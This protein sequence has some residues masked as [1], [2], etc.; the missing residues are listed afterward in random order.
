MTE[1]QKY[2]G[3]YS[4]AQ[5][6]GYGHSNHGH[7][8]M[9]LFL[10]WQPKSVLDVGC[11]YNEFCGRLK[12][13]ISGIKAIG[14]DFACPGADVRAT[15]TALPFFDKSFEVVTSF[16]CLEHLLPEEVE[17]ALREMARVASK[18]VFSIC[19]RPSVITWEGH[20][21]HPTVQPESWWIE[22]IIKAGGSNVSK[23][24]IYLT[25]DFT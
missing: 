8:S 12:A 5:Y 14:A 16:D 6:A 19:H 2:E 21:L 9:P 7:G 10:Q 3:I 13:R 17:P 24:N 25:G 18:F 23:I 15:A 20:N 1:L 4:S 11:G 22:Q